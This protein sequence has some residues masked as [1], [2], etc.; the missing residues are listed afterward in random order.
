MIVGVFSVRRRPDL[1]EANYAALSDRM[2]DIVSSH[3]EFGLIG[4]TG[5]KSEDGRALTMAFFED[6]DRMIAWK[7]QV[8]HAAAQQ[9]GR[10]AFFLDY[11][12]FVAEM[13]EA[14]E[15]ETG[16]GRRRVPLDSRWCPQGF[17]APA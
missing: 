7:Q 16:T 12:G 14:Y 10:E 17:D 11:W 6:R 5:Y 3:R 1:D 4:I 9:Q 15:F 13:V 8:E 2:W